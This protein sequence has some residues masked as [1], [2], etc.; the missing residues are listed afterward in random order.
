MAATQTRLLVLGAVS[1]FEPVNG[2]QIRRE[3]MSWEVDRWAHINPGSIYSCLTTLAKQG[4]LRRHDVMDGSREVA[5]Y[6][7]TEAGRAELTEMFGQALE[8]VEVLDPLPL[9]T[10]LSMCPL[11]SREVVIGHLERRLVALDA[12]LADLRVKHAAT[13]GGSAPPHVAR[14]VELLVGGTEVELA[15]AR[16]LLADI[17]AGSLWF[18]GE[19]MG[20]QPADDDPGWQMAADRDRY[21]SMLVAGGSGA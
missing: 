12:H 16:R 10:A 4:L 3:L 11:F 21:R 18:A 7:T 6:L 17:R 2:Y 1:L 15:W 14:V 9:H 8:T 13:A 20:W 19:P 5:V